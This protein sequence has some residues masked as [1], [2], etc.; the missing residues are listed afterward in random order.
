[1][2]AGTLC[3]QGVPVPMLHA[4]CNRVVAAQFKK[5]PCCQQDADWHGAAAAG[6]LVMIVLLCLTPVFR[7]MPQN[8]QGAIIIAAVIGLFNYSEWF[9]LWKVGHAL[10]CAPELQHT[11]V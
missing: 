11:D 6:V 2:E 10:A 3:A 4:S 7:N 9:F 5:L 1:M 8:A